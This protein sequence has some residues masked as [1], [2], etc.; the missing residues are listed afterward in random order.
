MGV[1]GCGKSSIGQRLA[2]R[3]GLPHIEG[4]AYHSSASV[5]KMSAGIPLTDDDRADW[6]LRLKSEIATRRDQGTG[7]VLS[8]S[9]LKRRYRDVLRGGA[10]DL[11]FFHLA[12]SRDLIASRMA[13]RANHYM[14]P[15]LLDSQFRDL[16]A[17][18]SDEAGLLLDIAED[19]QHIVDHI[20]QA[21][22]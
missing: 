11:L 6:L 22:A 3:L 18:A 12:G 13:A 4:D 1:S 15:S 9:A 21:L 10:P 16:E 20:V 5:T 17:L 7:V 14:P 8:C 2:E 19:P